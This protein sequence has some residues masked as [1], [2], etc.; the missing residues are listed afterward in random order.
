MSYDVDLTRKQRQLLV[1]FIGVMIVAVLALFAAVLASDYNHRKDA[2]RLLRAGCER[3]KRDRR[4]NAD[5]WTAHSLYIN[6]VVLAGSVKE[7]VKRAARHARK[8]YRR[9]SRDLEK[10]S[11]IDC[12]T[13]FP[14]PPLVSVPWQ[15]SGLIRVPVVP[16]VW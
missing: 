12:R 16:P 10:R 14:D 9:I 2:T 6:K 5:G 11:R 1:R 13:E 7:D 4:A 8:T 15:S 3:N